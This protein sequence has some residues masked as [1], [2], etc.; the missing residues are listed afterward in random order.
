MKQNF[1][2]LTIAVTSVPLAYAD[3]SS[4]E[5][6]LVTTTRDA[7]TMV[8][9]ETVDIKPD[10]AALLRQAPGANVNGN[11][12]LTGIQQYRGMYGDRINVAV[13]GAK[14]SAGGPNWMDPPLSYAPAAQ[15][16]SLTVYRGIAPVSVGQETIGG[17]IE[18]K[19][20]MGDFAS[21]DKWLSQGVIRAGGQTVNDAGQFS[22]ATA[23]ANDSNRLTI[24]AL[25]E[26]GNDAEF[27]DGDIISSEYDRQRYDIG[28]GFQQGGHRVQ[29]DVGRNETGD[30]G[31]P[32]LPMDISYI[33]SDL[34]SAVY[35]YTANDWSVKSKFYSSDIEHGMT[36]YHLRSAPMMGMM[37]RRNIATGDN[38]GFAMSFQQT[39]DA[40]SWNI[41][42]DGHFE[43]HNSNIDNPNNPL[44]FVVNFNDAQRDVLGIFAERKHTL[45]DTL[46][47]EVGARYNRV[48]MDANEVDGTP[49][50]MSMMGMS[51][52]ASLRDSF[53]GADRNQVDD[54]IDLVVKLYQQVTASTSAYIGVAR[55]NRAPSYQERYLWL[56]LQATA[57]LAD[58]H[59]YTGNI[60]LESEVASEIE[61]GVD[62][63]ASALTLSPRIFY[64]SVNDYI[65]GTVSNNQAAISLVMMMNTMNGTSNAAPLEFNNVDATLY[66]FDMDWRYRV[67]DHW[68]LSGIIN[69]VRGERDDIDDDLYRIAPLNMTTA[70]NYD[71]DG[72]SATLESVLYQS[73]NKVSL[74][75]SEQKT[76]GYGLLNARGSW[77][78]NHHIRVGMGI[79]NLMDKKFRDHLA[80]Y[81][82]V[83]NPDIAN[84]ERLPGYGR[85]VFAR[86][87]YQW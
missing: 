25:V 81:N 44:F 22:L 15:L 49:A 47:L 24:K 18:A 19:T 26:Q 8:I 77:E 12:P 2:A 5:E 64:R 6:M 61:F 33:D 78:V 34:Y 38:V 9:A 37:W 73:Q 46:Q 16:E 62:Y 30:T 52:G 53:N 7:R 50:S 35:S 85:N 86:V 82:R 54:N 74:I 27:P 10:T 32:A 40:G 60:N 76:D 84:G 56:P 51:P 58:G 43:E 71:A 87:D 21:S 57:G 69:Y 79:D 83:S 20:W 66:G 3:H 14:I 68:S 11:G 63:S 41:G 59:T 31:T 39:D 28:Y 29:F 1:L 23:I 72:W 70:I 75:N 4:V 45:S 67:T 80:G 42:V 48:E 65:Q 17:A 36:N 55:K 13:N